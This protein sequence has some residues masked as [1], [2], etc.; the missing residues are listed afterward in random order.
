MKYKI[1]DKVRLKKN[2]KY[3]YCIQEQLQKANHIVTVKDIKGIYY[4]FEE[5]DDCQWQER[6]IE[7]CL[8]GCEEFFEPI[9]IRFELMDL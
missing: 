5:T 3:I 6:Y 7:R 8:S 2:K 4:F 1:G 9:I